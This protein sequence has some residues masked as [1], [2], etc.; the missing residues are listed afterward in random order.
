MPT[1]KR[2]KRLIVANWKMNPTTKA[3]A[4]RLFAE[5]KKAGAKS[6]RLQ[7]VVCAP[8]PYLSLLA[9]QL[10]GHRTAL[11]AQDCFYERSGAF[12]GEV[13]PAQLTS[14]GVR[15]VILGHSE[16]RQM[17]ESNELVARKVAAALKEGL[18]VV[19]CVGESARDEEGLY[20]NA[21]KQQL[22][23]SLKDIPRRY[24]LNLVVAYEPIWAISTH[25]SGV[26][27]PEDM[28][29]MGIFIRKTLGAICG[30]DLAVKV[31]I[32]YGGSVDEKNIEAYITRGGVD[33]A[34]VGKASLLAETFG[35]IIK[36]A[37]DIKLD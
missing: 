20:L 6:T 37:N 34:L 24:F 29:Q 12:T 27:S 19:L 30:K 18:V 15:Y 14:L 26:E 21:I 1:E 10:S 31:P 8:F 28:L 32:L 2:G 9:D 25:A 16:R 36:I 5:A 22:E 33:G 7:T 17:G 4:L 13:S 23:E 3:D 11:G 35:K